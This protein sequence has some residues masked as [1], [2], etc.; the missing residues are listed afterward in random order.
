MSD[1]DIRYSSIRQ[2]LIERE[3]SRLNNMQQKAVFKTEGPLLLLAG[4][5]SGKTTVLINRIINLLRFGRA[6]ESPYAP[7]WAGEEELRKLA[8][9]LNDDSSLDDP[10]IAR[11]CAVDP[12]K[13]WEII[14]ITFT[15]KAA[16]ELKERLEAACGTAANDIWA[17]TF[18]SACT[19]ILRRDIEKIGYSKSFTIYD[20]DDKKKLMNTILKDMGY[21]TKRYDVKGI[22]AEIARAKDSLITPEVYAEQV[23]DDFYKKIVSRIYAEYQKRLM[24]ANALD[25]DD[26]IFKTVE[27]LETFEDVRT[28][29]QRKFRYVLVDEYQDTNYA[30]YVLCKIL[31]GGYEN[32]CVVGDDDQ[33]IYKFRGA[34]IANILEFEKQYPAAETIRLEQNYRSTSSILSAA[35]SVIS[36]NAAR[37]GKT[38]WTENGTGDAVY[39]YVGETQEEE[40]Q[41]IAKTILEGRTRGEKL[42]SFTILY[43]NHALSN[44]IEFAFKRN[45]IPYRI[46]AGHR[47]ADRAEVRDMI[48]YLWVISNPADT[49]RLSRI[50]N[51]PARK[52][53]AK[54]ID[55]LQETAVREGIS[56]FEAAERSDTYPELARSAPALQAF[57]GMIRE[58]QTIRNEVPMDELYD[59]LIAKSGYDIYLAGQG[60]EGKTRMENVLE[61]KSSILDYCEKHEDPTL[62]G[63]L[64][65][66]S[67]IADVDTFDED[68]DAVTLMTMHSAKGLEFD[69]VFI[70]GAE[71]GIFPSYRSMDSEEEIEEERRICYV[72]MTRAKKK[73]F[74]TSAK[75]RLLY[76][77]TSYGKLSRFVEEIDSQ[78]I[79][80]HVPKTAY[81]EARSTGA[82]AGTGA[83]ARRSIQRPSISVAP[84]K[85]S[86]GAAMHFAK[87]DLVVHK[88][89]GSGRIENVTP[90]GGDLLLEIVFESAGT[91]MMMAKTA[92]QYLAKI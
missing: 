20:E 24:A 41:F 38:L 37:K 25:F 40:G 31:A 12:P 4:A 27:L 92:A 81:S 15:N 86:A 22:I 85:E 17:H 19:R 69:T 61:L 77:Q 68:A 54:T 28:Y 78:Y 66:W 80:R 35:N 74:I 56:M 13:P 44:G 57:T 18:H 14:A 65:E 91:K 30:Q 51:V 83:P 53:G 23:G 88:A 8:H 82:G 48:A 89:F 9:A 67:L 62:E 70:C 5:G 55:T 47:F 1:F 75:R 29:Y 64:E 21:D 76:G 45:G 11:L 59:Q 84:K 90:M 58:L 26:I 10:E 42:N 72:A 43:R 6:Y 71:E 16:G 73:L 87:G 60:N 63:F 32:L 52:I 3:F 34:T 50:I 33:S 79:Q 49:I 7:D 36:N 46:V 2:S 39:L